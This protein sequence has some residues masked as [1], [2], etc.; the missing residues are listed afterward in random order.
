MSVV[1]FM[2]ITVKTGSSAEAV[3]ILGGILAETVER[4]GSLGV[5]I[6]KDATNHDHIVLVERWQSVED[7]EAYRQWRRSLPPNAEFAAILDGSPQLTR[8]E[9]ISQYASQVN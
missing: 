1:A 9:L 5:D 2:D 3:R 4:P 6:V 7:D 8:F